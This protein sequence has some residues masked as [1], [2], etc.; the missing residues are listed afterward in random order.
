MYNSIDI[1]ECA[2]EI[3]TCETGT[4]CIN[5]QGSYSCEGMLLTVCIIIHVQC[6]DCIIFIMQILMNAH[7]A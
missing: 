6:H 5:S 7:W 2:E 3:N 1:D 4:A